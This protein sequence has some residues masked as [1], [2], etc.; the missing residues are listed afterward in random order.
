MLT[1]ASLRTPFSFQ[2][3]FCT[4]SSPAVFVVVENLRKKLSWSTIRSKAGSV[5]GTR[6]NFDRLVGR[7]IPFVESRLNESVISGGVIQNFSAD[8]K[9]Y[10]R[11]N[12]FV[13]IDWYWF[14]SFCD[15][16]HDFDDCG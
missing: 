2:P 8:Y 6:H 1:F 11:R 15:F 5:Q 12:I 9:I 16:E 10:P 7:V 4:G 14:G 3:S 13:S